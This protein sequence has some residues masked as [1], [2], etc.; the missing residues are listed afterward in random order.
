MEQYKID[1]IKYRGYN[2]NVYQDDNPETPREWDNL[3]TMVC[4]HKRYILGDNKTGYK[5][6]DY[7]S[8]EGLAKQV[9]KDHEPLYILP[10]YLYD[11]SGLRLK[12]GSFQG[13]L[14]QGHAEFDSGQ[15]GFIFVSK[16]KIKEEW[17][18]KK[19]N[20]KLKEQVLKTL[21]SEVKTYDDYL[22]GN[23]YGFQIEDKEGNDIDS[24]W[25]FF[26]DYEED[27]LSEAKGQI[28]W[29]IKDKTKRHNQKLKAQIKN[30]TGLEYRKALTV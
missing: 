4:F 20:K 9:I 18:V 25:G 27:L 16:K 2:I 1:T 29:H 30:K 11:H 12:V 6:E 13:F 17:K 21:E 26:G 23:I 10:L 8:W 24:C 5:S 14:P 7:E 28:D 15:I 22:S 3:G 19:I